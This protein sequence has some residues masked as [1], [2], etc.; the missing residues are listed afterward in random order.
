VAKARAVKTPTWALGVVESPQGPLILAGEL[1]RQRIVWIAFDALESTWPLRISFPIFIANA[2]DWLNPAS[3]QTKQSLIPAGDP[4]RFPLPEPVDKALI[5][6]P[7]G[8]SH[9][10]PIDPGA[11]EFVFGDTSRRGVYRVALGTNQTVFCA[12]VLDTAESDIRP[13]DELDFGRFGSVQATTTR[14]AS[15]EIW[16]WIAAV[17]LG[18]L[19]FEWWFYHRRTA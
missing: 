15:L 14:R 18:V 1:A 9:A 12:N 11:A 2:V 16:R 17:A 8:D 4:F 6:M 10:V 3:V 7:G 19:L 13:R 5:T